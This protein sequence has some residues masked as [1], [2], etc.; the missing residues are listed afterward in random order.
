MVVDDNT[1]IIYVVKEKLERLKDA[2]K[3]TGVSSGKEC[4]ELLKKEK[5]RISSF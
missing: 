4:L 3:V 2:Y 5:Y 1:D